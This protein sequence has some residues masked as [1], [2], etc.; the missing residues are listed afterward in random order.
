MR[1]YLDAKAMA[2]HLRARLAEKSIKLSHGE[3]LELV[4]GQFGCGDWNELAARIA[5]E[6]ASAG[7]DDERSLAPRPT[8]F[9]VFQSPVRFYATKPVLRIFDID[10]ALEFYG[11]FL[12]FKVDWEHRFE[13]GLPLYM[14]ISRGR[15]VL[16]L[17]EH[18]GD[19]S[20]GSV[21]WVGMKGLDDF[22]H[23]LREK[24]YTRMRPGI[25]EMSPRLRVM[26]VIDPFGNRL[27]FGEL[28]RAPAGGDTGE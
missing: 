15:L 4:A 27:R 25:R 9:I 1:T 6:A 8:S 10:K 3:C 23:E 21:V 14:Q 20:P 19:G 24:S 11:D 18:H 28:R 2:K 7:K 26:E 13:P 12:G 5:Q 17:S 22:H 16:Q